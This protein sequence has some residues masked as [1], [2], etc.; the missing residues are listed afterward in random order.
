MGLTIAEGSTKAQG[1]KVKS[2]SLV[3]A[4]QSNQSNGRSNTKAGQQLVHPEPHQGDPT[5]SSFISESRPR[6][7]I[8]APLCGL[9]SS[10][11][12]FPA[13]DYPGKML[14]TTWSGF[15]QGGGG[16]GALA[17]VWSSGEALSLADSHPRTVT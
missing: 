12:G 14:E 11:L 9:A 1:S 17:L 8:H 10:H 3:R 6:C 5:S 16:E 7:F 2:A 13:R 15:D 4:A